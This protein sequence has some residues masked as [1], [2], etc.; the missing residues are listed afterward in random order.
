MVRSSSIMSLDWD[1]DAA[2]P[3]LPPGP[4]PT[5]PTSKFSSLSLEARGG[6]LSGGASLT[7]L[8]YA[9]CVPQEGGTICS[10]LKGKDR[11]TVCLWTKCRKLSHNN[12]GREGRVEFGDGVEELLMIQTGAEIGLSRPTISPKH[13]GKKWKATW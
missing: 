4:S 8:K 12:A 1:L 10:F 7:L 6:G 2:P 5:T 3:V 11:R 13:F 9:D